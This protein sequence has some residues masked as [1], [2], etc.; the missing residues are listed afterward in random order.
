[1]LH[2][3]WL[4]LIACGT[5]VKLFVAEAEPFF[6]ARVQ[7]VGKFLASGPHRLVRAGTDSSLRKKTGALAVIDSSVRSCFNSLSG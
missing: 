3:A 5:L 6:A 1:M 4:M 7:E 2:S